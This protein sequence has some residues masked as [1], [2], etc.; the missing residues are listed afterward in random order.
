MLRFIVGLVAFLL[1]GFLAVT[2]IYP[3]VFTTVQG[4]FESNDLGVIIAL[5]ACVGITVPLIWL[6]LL[7]VALIVVLTGFG[8][9][10]VKLNRLRAQNRKRWDRK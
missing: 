6:V 9:E 1:V 8:Q 4:M 7:F 3:W 2:V 10:E 5:L